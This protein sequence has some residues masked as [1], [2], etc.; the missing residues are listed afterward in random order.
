VDLA[1][2]EA[3]FANVGNSLRA[4]AH[5]PDTVNFVWPLAPPPGPGENYV[6]LRSDD[7]PR[8]PFVP[9]ATI[10]TT[11]WTDPAAPPR[12]IP[13]HVWYYDLRLADSCANMSLD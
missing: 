4:T 5:T 10:P 8:G 9:K 12:Y 6:M 11:S 7:D 3:P 13:V 2:T 1:D